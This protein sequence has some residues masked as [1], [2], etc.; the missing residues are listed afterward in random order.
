MA[1]MARHHEHPADQNPGQG[2]QLFQP[3]YDH[4]PPG[5]RSADTGPRGHGCRPGA[6]DEFFQ[7]R[8]REDRPDAWEQE[9]IREFLRERYTRR[10]WIFSH[11]HPRARMGVGRLKTR[12]GL[13]EI[14]LVLSGGSIESVM[15][16]GD[17]FAASGDIRRLE[18]ALK[19]SSAH[20]ERIA[21]NLNHVWRE[22]MIHGLDVPTLTAAILK[23][24]ENQTRL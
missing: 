10:E 3:A 2:L 7:A 18:S 20:E 21:E 17:F 9:R 1:L 11:K 14:Y 8:L 19:W 5:G 4:H 12:A 22:D 13:L 15:I 24:K 6:F 16:T 23:A